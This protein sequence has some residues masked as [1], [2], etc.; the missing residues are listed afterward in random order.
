MGCQ[1]PE[2]HLLQKELRNRCQGNRISADIVRHDNDITDFADTAALCSHMDLVISVDTSVA[3]MAG[4]LGKHNVD[5]GVV[6]G[7]AL[8]TRSDI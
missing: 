3:H 4:A 6:A 5:A 2:Y 1:G 8:G 7:L